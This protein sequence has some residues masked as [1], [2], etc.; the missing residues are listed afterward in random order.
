MPTDL[1]NY[2]VKKKSAVELETLEKLQ[3]FSTCAEEIRDA[4]YLLSRSAQE[5]MNKR[6]DKYVRNLNIIEHIRNSFA[7]GNVKVLDN[8]D[9][10]FFYDRLL[11]I[12][13]IYYGKVTYKKVIKVKDFM[14][15]FSSDN[16]D[17]LMKFLMSL[18]K[19]NSC[20]LDDVKKLEKK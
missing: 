4:N 11:E 9:G 10:D 8:L 19:N 12:Q 3:L 15:L 20:T 13:D 6:K 7:H 1:R 5:F 18:Q 16:L 2:I 17:V 14:K